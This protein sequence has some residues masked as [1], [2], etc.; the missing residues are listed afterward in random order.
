MNKIWDAANVSLRWYEHM[1]GHFYGDGPGRLA[2]SCYDAHRPRQPRE[3]RRRDP[4][5]PPPH[6]QLH[7]NRAAAGLT[8]SRAKRQ[9]RQ[10]CRSVC[11]RLTSCVA[12]LGELAHQQA[13]TQPAVGPGPGATGVA[14]R[15]GSRSAA[16]PPGAAGVVE[17]KRAA[18]CDART[19]R[20]RG[21]QVRRLQHVGQRAE[22]RHFAG[23]P[24]AA[25]RLVD[26]GVGAAVPDARRQHQRVFG[27]GIG[28]Q[29]IGRR[30]QRAGL[31][32]TG[33]QRCWNSSRWWKSVVRSGGWPSVGSTRPAH[34]QAQ[35][36]R[37]L[38]AAW[39]WP[40]RVPA[41]GCASAWAGGAPRRCRSWPA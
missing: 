15:R 32:G 29:R 30:G 5:W 20:H 21:H 22:V 18:R 36:H 38:P 8:P 24:A 11:R 1:D 40:R 7:R 28:L 25:R 12:R 13:I 33:T 37:G 17:L 31:C 39:R 34:F 16:G 27:V 3:L 14:R 35:V 26:E 4:A 23:A 41:A 6:E 19:P 2:Y 10:Q 9:R